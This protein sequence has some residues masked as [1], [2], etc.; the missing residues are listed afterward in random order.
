MKT[1]TAEAIGGPCD[2]T[3]F[4]VEVDEDGGLVWVSGHKPYDNSLRIRKG[5]FVS[6]RYELVGE[7]LVYRG[8]VDG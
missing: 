8:L 6:H 1:V 3:S 7:R 2:G 5:Q 4:L